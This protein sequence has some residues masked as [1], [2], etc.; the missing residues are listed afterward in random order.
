MIGQTLNNRYKIISQ[1]GEGGMGEVYLASDEKSK[2]EV[3]VKIL[4]K[5][6]ITNQGLIDRFK[7]EAETLQ[8][9]DH[10]NIVKFIDAFEHENQYVIVM[11]HVS[12]GSLHDLLKKGSLSIELARRI[13]LELCDALIRSHHLNIIHRDIKPENVLLTKDSIPKLADFGVARLSEAEQMTRTG[14]QVGTPYYMAPEAW[15]GKV[16]DAQA[17]IWSLGVMFFEMLAGQVPFNGDTPLAVMSQVNTASLPN[18]RKLRKDIPNNFIQIINRMLARDKKKRYQTMREVVVDLEQE[19]L[20][21]RSFQFNWGFVVLIVLISAGVFFSQTF[22]TQLN[23]PAPVTTTITS[24]SV[25][26]TPTSTLIPTLSIETPTLFVTPTQIFA[27]GSTM[28]S[29]IDG[30]VL[31]YVPAG[32]F[33]MG[34]ASFLDEQPVH[35]VHL[36]AY[37]IDETEV[38]NKM[39]SQCAQVD[40]C[41]LPK[42]LGTFHYDT[43]YGNSAFDNYPVVYINWNMAKAYC[44]WAGRRLP[45]EAE[46]EKAAR[47]TD[48]RTYPWGEGLSCDKASIGNYYCRKVPPLPI[49]NYPQG[50]SIYKAYDMAGNVMEWVSSL[51]HPYPYNPNDGREDLTSSNA[52]VMR[53]GSSFDLTGSDLRSAN[54]SRDVPISSATDIGFRCAL[55]IP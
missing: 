17:D 52:R 23:Q 39:Y 27:I 34:S 53:G 40:A 4:A 18:L 35:Q 28:V 14:T 5:Q 48:G 15:E 44:E 11:E 16:L 54:R 6:L 32:E 43:Y 2:Q 47:G 25:T 9:L 37:W 31:V 29:D 19:G 46:W 3:A 21:P 24:I 20:I 8:K 33:T 38:T 13:T 7:R 50:I 1:L 22:I 42:N 55:S 10:P 12:E 30:M 36:D 51:Y 45:T 26:D 41:E 49:K